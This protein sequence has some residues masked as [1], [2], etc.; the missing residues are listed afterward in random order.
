[1]NNAIRTILAVMA[2]IVSLAMALGQCVTDAAGATVCKASWL[3]PQ[4]S[5]YLVA[6]LTFAA[7]VLKAFRS[8]GAL[9][10][11]FGETAV[12]SNSGKA[13]T[14]APIDVVK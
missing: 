14:V 1:M 11:L 12:V 4:M 3:T 9:A 6:G 13:G 2:T 10:G 8:G 7:L 5:G